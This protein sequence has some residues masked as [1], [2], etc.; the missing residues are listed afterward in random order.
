MLNIISRHIKPPKK[1]PIITIQA[2]KFQKLTLRKEVWSEK[3]LTI[4]EKSRKTLQREHRIIKK[5]YLELSDFQSCD[6]YVGGEVN[7]NKTCWVQSARL[8]NY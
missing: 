3:N 4:L 2:K 1:Y 8:G 7:W 5:K 6:N